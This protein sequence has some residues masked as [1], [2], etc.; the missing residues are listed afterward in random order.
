MYQTW[1]TLALFAMAAL[2]P[3]GGLGAARRPPVTVCDSRYTSTAVQPE[4]WEIG[5]ERGLRVC[6]SYK[7]V[8]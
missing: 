6:R 2:S 5:S 1:P 7:K 8:G 4:P 3:F